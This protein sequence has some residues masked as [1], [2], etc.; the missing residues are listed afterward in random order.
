M[1]SINFL[2]V[3]FFQKNDL[4]FACISRRAQKVLRLSRNDLKQHIC[5]RSLPDFLRGRNARS[6]NCLG[7]SGV[8][9]HT[10]ERDPVFDFI[11]FLICKYIYMYISFFYFARPELVSL[12]HTPPGL[13]AVAS[14]F[15]VLKL[16]WWHKLVMELLSC[17]FGSNFC[18]K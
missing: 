4:L 1:A 9:F 14:K 6:C 17:K 10:A 5:I 18:I 3:Y 7:C 12:K 11:S 16:I 2:I 8:L 13:Q 15:I